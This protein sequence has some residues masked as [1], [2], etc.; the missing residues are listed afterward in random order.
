VP[1]SGSEPL[2]SSDAANATI[3]ITA[4][5]SPFVLFARWMKISIDI[6][7]LRARLR[8]GTHAFRV[9]PGEH[10]VSVGLG[11]GSASKAVLRVAVA[12]HETI[13]LCYRPRMI[14]NLPGKLEIERL[15][16]ARI[17]SR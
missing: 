17:H 13:R 4:E 10:E 7:G 12:A 14:K 11:P 5:S 9:A 1:E 6:D 8:W 2:D 3:E 15:P 16:V